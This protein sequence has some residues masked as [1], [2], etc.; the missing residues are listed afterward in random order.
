[1]HRNHLTGCKVILDFLF[2]FFFTGSEIIHRCKANTT[3]AR[4]QYD[5][6]VFQRFFKWSLNLYL[7]SLIYECI[8]LC[9]FNYS[10]KFGQNNREI[11]CNET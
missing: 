6:Y 2:T 4:Y 11:Q 8:K 9:L 10:M 3:V 7:V 5:R 1:M